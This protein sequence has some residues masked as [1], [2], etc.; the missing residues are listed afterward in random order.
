MA[1]AAQ[2]RFVVIGDSQGIR[3]AHLNPQRIGKSMSDD[4]SDDNSQALING[5]AYVAL[6]QGSIGW[7]MRGKAPI[8]STDGAQIIA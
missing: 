6:D 3:L 1:Q 4:D 8:F 2:A 7:S 5:Q